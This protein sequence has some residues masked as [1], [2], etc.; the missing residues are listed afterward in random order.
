MST[1]PRE[2]NHEKRATRNDI[3]V[4]MNDE[5]PFQTFNK[6][7]KARFGQRVQ[8][9]P[10]HAGMTC[11]NRDGTKGEGGCIYC[12]N[13]SFNMNLDNSESIPG[14]IRIGI[15]KARR[16]YKAAL[17]LAYF[18]TYSNTYAPVSKLRKMYYSALE[19]PD[20]VGLMVGTRPDC[21]TDDALELLVEI[22]ADKLVWVELGVQSVHDSTLKLINRGH[23]FEDSKRTIK[24]IHDAGLPVAVHI[25]LGLPDE[26]EKQ[27]IETADT[28][29]K[30]NVEG[31]KLHHLHAVKDTVLL[32]MYEDGRWI[33]FTEDQYIQLAVK[34]LKRFSPEVVVM[35]LVGECPKHLLV[36]PRWSLSKIEIHNRIIS[37]YK[38]S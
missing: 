5:H 36:A 11:P 20:V 17:F 38:Q 24:R 10:I 25:I 34:V 32:R 13:R 23:T 16:R 21:L 15:Q 7:L 22:A 19:H 9:I 8:R 26:T 6:Y 2:T 12:D 4:F 3:I 29:S 35:R 30:L 27:M 33:P 37:T 1:Q 31:I 14:Q 18:Q 28:L